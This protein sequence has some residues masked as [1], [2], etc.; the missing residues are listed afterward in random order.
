[1]DTDTNKIIEACAN[2][3]EADK[4]VEEYQKENRNVTKIIGGWN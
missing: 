2:E 4:I 1:M 3:Q